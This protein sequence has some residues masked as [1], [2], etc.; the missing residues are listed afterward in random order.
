M[1]TRTTQIAFPAT[2]VVA[3]VLLL[4][5]L[6]I[7]AD[8]LQI[9]NDKTQL[10]AWFGRTIKNYK[11][12]RATLD[13]ELVKA[14]DNLKI[15]KV[16]KSGGGDFKTVTDAVNSVPAGNTGR[17]MIWIG[18]GVYEEKKSRLIGLSPSSHSTDHPTTCPC[19]H[20]TG[21]RPSTGRWTAPA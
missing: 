4:L 17:V 6:I 20:S 15:I 9:P 18:G 21:R 14:E 7:L 12:R 11:L 8:D 2:A 19:C 16:S 10:T 5:P 1:A 3:L 13:P